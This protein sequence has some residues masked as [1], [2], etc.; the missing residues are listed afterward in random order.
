MVL[1]QLVA[2]VQSTYKDHVLHA[3]N[4]HFVC[5]YGGVT[6]SARQFRGGLSSLQMRRSTELLEAHLD[7]KLTVQQVAEACG[8]VRST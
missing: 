1:T 8:L 4:C 7:G 3:L 6:V 5:A 2:L